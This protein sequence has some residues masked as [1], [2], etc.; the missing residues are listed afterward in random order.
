M[1]LKSYKKGIPRPSTESRHNFIT[2]SGKLLDVMLTIK[3]EHHKQDKISKHMNKGEIA[4]RMISDYSDLCESLGFKIPFEIPYNIESCRNHQKI[5]LK[6][7]TT[8]MVMENNRN[9]VKSLTTQIYIHGKALQL[10]NRTRQYIIENNEDPS[11][12]VIATYYLERH[13]ALIT[14]LDI[15]YIEQYKIKYRLI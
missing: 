15:D 6:S 7:G 12:P 11:I 5:Q 10:V 13:I 8:I 9:L 14:Q 1:A 3:Q 2:V 4:N